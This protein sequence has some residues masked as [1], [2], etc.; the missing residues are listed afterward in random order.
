MKAIVKVLVCAAALS[1]AAPVSAAD[2]VLIVQKAASDVGAPKTNQIQIEQHR[3]RAEI[4]GPSGASQ[5]M[6]FDGIREA[7]LMIDDDHKTYSE[8]TKADVEAISQ[9]MSA[10]MAQMQGAMKNM[11][12]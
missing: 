2:G 5:S 12:P 6:V 10:A 11:T 7:M 8:I 9:Q 4:A 1:M 3:M